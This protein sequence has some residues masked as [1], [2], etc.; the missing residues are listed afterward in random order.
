LDMC[1]QFLD[2][3][4]EHFDLFE[5]DAEF[6]AP[7]IPKASSIPSASEPETEAWNGAF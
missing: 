4:D 2:V 7:Y 3:L 1:A 6:A 5:H